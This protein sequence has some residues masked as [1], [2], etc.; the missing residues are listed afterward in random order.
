MFNAAFVRGTFPHHQIVHLSF[1]RFFLAE[2]PTISQSLMDVN[3]TINT[4]PLEEEEDTI[5][6]DGNSSIFSHS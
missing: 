4:H 6:P 5:V 3:S 1:T 2:S